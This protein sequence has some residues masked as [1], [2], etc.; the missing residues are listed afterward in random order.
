[1]N[2]PFRILNVTPESSPEEIKR[3]YKNFVKLY[4]PDIFQGNKEAATEKMKELNWAINVLSDKNQFNR[5]ADE[6]YKSKTEKEF[7]EDQYDSYSN[8]FYRY[9][10]KSKS[11]VHFEEED[12]KDFTGKS[13]FDSVTPLDRFNSA[14]KYLLIGFVL[15]TV[16][17]CLIILLVQCSTDTSTDETT[18]SNVSSTSSY[19]NGK[20]IVYVTRTG[21]KYHRAG[22][23]YLSDS[24]REISLEE[25]VEK[26]Y[27]RCSKCNPPK[28][29]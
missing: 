15:I 10:S 5:F 2:N 28:L 14:K 8:G 27:S 7:S 16:A 4:H 12:E 11:K 23:G 19:S 1:M 22:C 25:A 26:G 13:G 18:Y 3:A 6:Y 24:K 20:Q 9:A 29:E 17:L 21:K